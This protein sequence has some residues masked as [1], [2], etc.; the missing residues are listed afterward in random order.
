MN[1]LT[2]YI[3]DELLCHGADLVGCGDLSEIPPEERFQLPVGISVAVKYPKEVIRNIFEEP[4]KDYFDQYNFL[5]EKLD[6]LVTLG[7]DALKMLGY[8][9]I[10]QTTDFVGKTETEYAS[11]LPH[12]T[13]ATR[14]GLGWIGKNALLVT[15]QYGSMIRLSSILTNAPLKTAQPV[16]QSRCGNCMVC[17]NACP[18][19]AVLGKNW[20]VDSDRD[21]IVDVR[22]CRK[23]ARERAMKA[24]GEVITLCGKCIVVCPY[25]QKYLNSDN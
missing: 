3:K 14:A 11:L 17:S 23:V 22:L 19:H 9:A 16:N 10:A 5:S 6:R 2:G 21:E 7:A 8:E 18:A 13:V 24:I 15:K 12:K 20:S 1:D 4:T 25:T